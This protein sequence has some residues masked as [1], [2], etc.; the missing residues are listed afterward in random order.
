VRVKPAIKRYSVEQLKHLP[1]RTRRDAPI[2]PVPK[3]FWHHARVMMPTGTKVPIHLRVDP[4]V[5]AW[6]RAQG[7][8]HLSR[9]NAVLRSFYEA[10]RP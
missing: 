10:N 7:P 2:L 5:L 9:M 4:D 6:F 1:D 8:G 3:G